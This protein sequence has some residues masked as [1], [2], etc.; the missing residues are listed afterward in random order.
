M[1]MFEVL[2]TQE[3][4]V[5]L[6]K[7]EAR[8]I[9]AGRGRIALD[10]LVYG[11]DKGARHGTRGSLASL[12]AA[13]LLHP[14]LSELGFARDADHLNQNRWVLGENDS[15]LVI[16]GGV[17]QDAMTIT[18]CAIGEERAQPH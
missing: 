7:V 16:R 2:A 15:L 9:D 14:C 3:V 17:D 11:G 8:G 18:H 13:K 6:A 1:D 10:G 5:A 4:A 12:L